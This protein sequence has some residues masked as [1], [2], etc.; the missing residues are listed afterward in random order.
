MVD[1]RFWRDVFECVPCP[2]SPI[3]VSVEF[4]KTPARAYACFQTLPKLVFID[5][6]RK[7]ALADRTSRAVRGCLPTVDC[8]TAMAS[9]SDSS[10]A[11]GKRKHSSANDDARIASLKQKLSDTDANSHRLSEKEA[12]RRAENAD[13]AKARGR[14]L[15]KQPQAQ[16]ALLQALQAPQQPQAHNATPRIHRFAVTEVM[17]VA[18]AFLFT[19]EALSCSVAILL[20]RMY[21]QMTSLEPGGQWIE[22]AL[23]WVWEGDPCTYRGGS[24]CPQCDVTGNCLAFLITHMFLVSG[25]LAACARLN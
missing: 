8:D 23:G 21:F 12:L 2:Q 14:G 24:G 16:Q 22:T 9:G 3:P 1:S 13:R 11:L 15:K 4:R 7:K 20:C 5:W 19:A 6:T 18:S 10:S 25:L 17:L